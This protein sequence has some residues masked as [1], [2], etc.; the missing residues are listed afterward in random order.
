M[1]RIK[2]FGRLIGNSPYK[3]ERKTVLE[4]IEVGLEAIDAKS[5]I[6]DNV[7]LD[8]NTLKIKNETV[9]LKK[10][11]NIFVFG[12]GK[13]SGLMAEEIEKI[14]GSKLSKGIV[15]SV[16]NAKTKRIKVVKGT[17]PIPSKTNLKATEKIVGLARKAKSNDLVICLISGGGSA[18][19]CLP[20]KGISL[21]QLQKIN[22]MLIKSG[23][24][25]GEIN[26]V[27]KHL[28]SVKGGLLAKEAFPAEVISLIISDVVDDKIE[29]I[30]SGP[31]A[32]DST[33]YNDAI[34]VL[35]KYNLWDKAAASIRKHLLNGLHRQLEE[36]PKQNS[37]VFKN[38]SNFIVMNNV[39][40]LNAIHKRAFELNLNPTIY[41]SELTGE[42]SRIGE[43]L[44]K[45]AAM[46]AFESASRNILFL[47][48]GETSVTVKGR[49]KG[50]RNLELVLGAVKE[51]SKT[52]NAVM[53]SF[54]TDGIDG[55]SNA[56]GAIADSDSLKMAEEKGLKIEDFLQNNDSFG[57]FNK[58][59]DCIYTGYTKT[60]VMD[61]QLI[62]IG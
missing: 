49:G 40:A 41:T 13:A 23:A 15:I 16:G 61:L 3:E 11:K 39:V 27:R 35:K 52:K 51:L 28:S 36:T 48:G 32:P 5:A 33:T 24:P 47:A 30:A 42:A 6:R 1:H 56:A 34:Q 9:N 8:K 26:T 53:A 37:P 20:A 45:R 7:S 54:A 60:N 58:L 14:L 62:L 57:F 46:T 21:Q 31:T 12:C 50:G 2:N 25:I 55:N 18:L 44:V 43:K 10:I 17:H 38:V 4:L 22:E 59:N 29:T 19:L